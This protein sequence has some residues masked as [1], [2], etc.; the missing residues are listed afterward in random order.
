MLESVVVEAGNQN[1]SG[2]EYEGSQYPRHEV[3]QII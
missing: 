1:H 3:E 2:I